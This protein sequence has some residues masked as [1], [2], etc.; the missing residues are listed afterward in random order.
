MIVVV[1]WSMIVFIMG[2][3]QVLVGMMVK[4]CCDPSAGRIF[5]GKVFSGLIKNENSLLMTH[6]T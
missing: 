1:Q 6:F 4:C 3:I 2:S 5:R